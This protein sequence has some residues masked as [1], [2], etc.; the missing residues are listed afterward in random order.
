MSQKKHVSW[1]HTNCR[2]GP[3]DAQLTFAK[4]C[5]TDGNREAMYSLYLLSLH[6]PRH[7]FVKC[8]NVVSWMSATLHHGT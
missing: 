6:I 2:R 7:S 1:V 3:L 5:G 4:L 8:V